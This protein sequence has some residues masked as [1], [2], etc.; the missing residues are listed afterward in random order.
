MEER[1]LNYINGQLLEPDSGDYLDNVDPSTGEVYSTV[2]DSNESDLN[3]AVAAAKAAFP[4]WR[5]TPAAERAAV[6]T[7]W[8]DLIESH[9][10]DFA[11]AECFD[12]GKPLSTCRNVDIPRGINNIR[13]YAT[14]VQQFSSECHPMGSS[15][16]NYTLRD[17]MGV[18]S[19]ISPWNFPFHLLTWK[20]APALAVGN[21]VIAKPSEVTPMTAGLMSSLASEAGVPPG[22]FNV[23]H[24]RGSRIGAAISQH[25]GIRAVSFT[26]STATGAE[27]SRQAAA[28]FKKV[29]LELGGKNPFIVFDDCD[30][31]ATLQGARASAYANQG[32][33]CLCGSRIFV[34]R[35]VYDRFKSD[36]SKV[37]RSIQ[38][39]DPMDPSTQHGA[40]VSQAQMEKVLGYLDLAREEGGQVLTG[41]QRRVL[42]GRCEKGFFIEPTLI[43]GL[44]YDSRCNQEEIFGPVATLIPFDSEE[45]VIEMANSVNYGL[46]ASLWTQ[47]L[48]RAHRM[49]RALESGIVWINTWNMRDLRT[50]FGGMKASGTG[51]EGG[52]ESLRFFTEAKNVCVKLD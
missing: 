30:W 19:T 41:G 10:E 32:Q 40:T 2:A 20:V 5:D 23:L 44:P 17:P 52:W 18:V 1:V 15:A 4:A 29:S 31:D 21:A 22:V 24:G 13:F 33:I 46:A 36:F 25:P 11:K 8:A 48:N 50:P 7:R 49:A 47:N 43:E 9:A 12:N 37:V 16:F 27:I 42:P 45:E 14:A 34:Q 51:R 3:T 28:S 26:G 38:V 39:G 35:S 6:L